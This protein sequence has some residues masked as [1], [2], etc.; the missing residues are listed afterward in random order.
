MRRRDVR[1]DVFTQHAGK[2]YSRPAGGSFTSDEMFCG[3]Q[4]SRPAGGSFFQDKKFIEAR[5]ATHRAAPSHRK[6]YLRE[7]PPNPPAYATRMPPNARPTGSTSGAISKIP[8]KVPTQS[9]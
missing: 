1:P 5:T 2:S 7:H 9:C 4:Y 6:D 3:I 8:N